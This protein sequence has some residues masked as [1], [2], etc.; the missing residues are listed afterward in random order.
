MA[1][2][3]LTS[4]SLKLIL[5]VTQLHHRRVIEAYYPLKPQKGKVF[6]II[7]PPQKTLICERQNDYG[8]I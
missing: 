1:V 8:S 4:F 3:F 7:S 6:S 2:H 5:L